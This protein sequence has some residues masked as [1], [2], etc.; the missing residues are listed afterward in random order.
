ML[1]LLRCAQTTATAK[2]AI[3]GHLKRKPPA[4]VSLPKLGAS[5]NLRR[6][7]DD[8]SSHLTP[9]IAAHDRVSARRNCR[10]NQG[11]RT[12]D[13]PAEVENLAEEL[14]D[15]SAT[16]NETLPHLVVLVGHQTLASRA[17]SERPAKQNCA[18]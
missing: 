12:E 18:A 3:G 14:A 2:F 16:L 7:T 10:E 17:L 8:R 13:D 1:T 6:R 11:G 9:G 15:I 4:H 5:R